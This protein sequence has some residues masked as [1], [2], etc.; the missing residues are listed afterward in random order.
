MLRVWLRVR[1]TLVGV[2]KVAVVRTRLMAGESLIRIGLIPRKAMIRARLEARKALVRI[3]LIAGEC[4]VGTGPPPWE[5]IVRTRRPRTCP[6]R[7]ITRINWTAA[8]AETWT[9]AADWDDH[10]E[11]YHGV[12]HY[13]KGLSGNPGISP[14]TPRST[15]TKTMNRMR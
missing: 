11:L 1:E 10:V 9:I 2:G 15:T 7:R 8:S 5:S 13:V 12:L 4:I 14:I 3:R 6:A